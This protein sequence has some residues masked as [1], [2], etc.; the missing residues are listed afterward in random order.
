[1]VLIDTKFIS[2]IVRIAR[3]MQ[4]FAEVN[5]ERMQQQQ[6]ASK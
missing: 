3:V 1:M 2:H 4:K 5:Q 6:N